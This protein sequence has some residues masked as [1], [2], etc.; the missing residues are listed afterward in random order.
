MQNT[1]IYDYMIRTGTMSCSYADSDVTVP[2]SIG[3]TPRIKSGE[4]SA[5]CVLSSENNGLVVN[6][7]L[8]NDTGLSVKINSISLDTTIALPIDTPLFCNGYQSWSASGF[9]NINEGLK[10]PGIFSPKLMKNS[11]DYSFSKYSRNEAHSWTYTYF[12]SPIG[13][14]LIASLD[15]SIAYTC[16]KFAK[17]ENR[18]AVEVKLEKDCEGLVYEP[19]SRLSE[20]KVDSLKIMHMFLA[21]GQENDCWENYFSLF[22]S[23]NKNK[24]LF[25]KSQPAIAWDSSYAMLDTLEER[26][27]SLIAQEYKN[28]NIPLDYFI[29]GNG[30]ETQFGDWLTVNDGFPNEMRKMSELIK[31]AGFKPGITFSP[32][33]CSSSSLL[34]NERRELLV[35]DKSGKP[36]CIGYNRRLGGK[37]YV[38]DI[39]NQEGENY[40]KRCM[41]VFTQD[42]KME[43]I[44]ADMLFAASLNSGYHVKRTR[45]QAMDQAMNILKK[46]AG[47]AKLI[48]CAIP[49]GSAFGLTEYCSVT[50]D[51]S[52]SWKEKNNFTYSRERES[53]LQAI[54]NAITRRHLDCRAFSSDI[55]SFTLRKY[56]MKLTKE[57][58][59]SFFK[60]SNIF[61]SLITG[62]DRLSAYD[63]EALQTFI[64][65][66]AL[67]PSRHYDK[68]I[69]SVLFK[70]E[71]IFVEYLL[72]G[73]KKKNKINFVSDLNIYSQ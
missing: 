58:K 29:I 53:T 31:E 38:V 10:S 72:N 34:F 5:H 1:K 35:S 8:D 13:Y 3:V 36:L 57:E 18:C 2:I 61:S 37:I 51:L 64:E 62:S 66:I 17:N 70:D 55:G 73:V 56:R 14:T 65:A 49:L 52:I 24:G 9:T 25:N 48:T 67:H 44:R 39:F 11:G 42:W 20:I 27:L 12:N 71:S 46:Y 33:V 16:I 22:Y 41:R 40:I 21:T 63:D 47:D 6:V 68:K 15:E 43:I 26:K 50:P 23:V 4:I 54:K 30:Y 19:V 60:V 45:A 32:F 7:L 69:L 59:F 28:F